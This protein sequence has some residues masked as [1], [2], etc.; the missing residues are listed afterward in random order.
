MKTPLRRYP[1]HPVAHRQRQAAV[2]QL[3]QLLAGQLAPPAAQRA[4]VGLCPR[5]LAPGRLAHDRLQVR[6]RGQQLVGEACLARARAQERLA[7][8]DQRR[9]VGLGRGGRVL[10]GRRLGRALRPARDRRQQ[11]RARR[12]PAAPDAADP[13]ELAR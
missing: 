1:Q 11:L 9:V 4:H 6:A 2:E 7:E 13:L 5:L 8:R 10:V 3:E 12:R